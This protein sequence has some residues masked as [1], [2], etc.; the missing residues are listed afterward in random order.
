MV[1]LHPNLHNLRHWKGTLAASFVWPRV[2]MGNWISLP[3]WWYQTLKQWMT[4]PNCFAWLL[5]KR[6]KGVKPCGTP[7]RKDLGNNLYLSSN[8]KQ[9]L[10]ETRNWRENIFPIHSFWSWLGRLPFSTVLKATERLRSTRMDATFQ[11]WLTHKSTTSKI[12]TVSL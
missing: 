10:L 8:T 1:P 12:R 5:N 4:S 7:Q 6:R 9:N 11:S 2:E 3:F